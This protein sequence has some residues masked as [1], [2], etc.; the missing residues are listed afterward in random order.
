MAACK[1][2]NV[3][4]QGKFW[5]EGLSV[6]YYYYYEKGSLSEMFGSTV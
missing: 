5:A 4:K 1:G 6:S 2:N 3:G